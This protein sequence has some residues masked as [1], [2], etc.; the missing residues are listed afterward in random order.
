MHSGWGTVRRLVF[1]LA[2]VVVGGL[3]V[4][5]AAGIASA[6]RDLSLARTDLEVAQR[7]AL[8]G[9]NDDARTALGQARRRLRSARTRAT[10]LPLQLLSPVPLL[11]SPGRAV[12][13]GARAGLELAAAGNVVL[14]ADAGFPTGASTTLDGADLR[15]FHGAARRAADALSQA[16]AHVD[17]AQHVLDGPSGAMLPGVAGP[18]QKIRAAVDDARRHLEGARRGIDLLAA[19][20]SPDADIRILVLAQ[21]SLELRPTGGYVGSYGVLRFSHATATLERYDATEALPP[22]DPPAEPPHDLAPFLPGPWRLSNVNWWP[23]FPT[24]ARA[25][26]EMFRRQGGGDVAGVMAL[27]EQAMAR[28]VGALGPVTVPGYGEPVTEKGFDDRV[29]YEVELKKPQDVP[30]KRFLIQLARVLFDRMF[31][32]S[33]DRVPALARALQPA[34]GNGEIQVWFRDPALQRWVDG[35]AISGALP[36]TAGDFLLLADANVSATKANLG[37]V[38]EVTYRVRRQGDGTLRARLDVLV[39]NEAPASAVNPGYEGY[40]RVYVPA[41]ARLVPSDPEDEPE[42][43]DDGPYR[44]LSRRVSV[45]PLGQQLLSFDY[46]LP[47]SLAPGGRYRL[48]WVRQPGTPRDSYRVVAGRRAADAPPDQRAVVLNR[49]L[50]G[51]GIGEWLRNRWIVRRLG[52]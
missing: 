48:T 45:A 12:V 4:I 24:T 30:R 41:L 46:V 5:S 36:R 19:L 39:R 10:G 27:T 34:M 49:R 8:D 32:V 13:D 15:P 18:A 23:D 31:H 40:R 44:V 2:T 29:V 7:A 11:G 52:L 37:L 35:T 28:L 38:K 20:S 47:A 22:P 6:R 21:D 3:V 43:A 26:A 50:G 17:Q 25:A 1:L 14:D 33:G 9:Q 16:L 51:A 42:R